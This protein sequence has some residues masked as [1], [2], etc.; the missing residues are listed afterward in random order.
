MRRGKVA[1]DIDSMQH[2]AG[3][4]FKVLDLADTLHVIDQATQHGLDLVNRGLAN[5]GAPA[6]QLSPMTQKLL[7]V[8]VGDPD[9]HC[10]RQ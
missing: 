6:F 4:F 9:T 10:R 1:H 2:A 3:Q 8:E 7:S 5:H